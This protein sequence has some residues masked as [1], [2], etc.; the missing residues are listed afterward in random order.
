MI[1][2]TWPKGAGGRY[3]QGRN[4]TS[5]TLPLWGR[6]GSGTWPVV[7][8]SWLWDVSTTRLH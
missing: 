3:H 7:K 1:V 2:I 5:L 4:R 8:R 6:G